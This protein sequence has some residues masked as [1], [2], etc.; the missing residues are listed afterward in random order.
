[1]AATSGSITVI[2]NP[3]AGSL[4]TDDEIRRRS[5][6]AAEVIAAHGERAD[7]YVTS[8]Q[9]EGLERARD[10]VAAG[11]RLVIAWGG[12]GTVNEVAAAVA[13]G[14]AAL[15]I[16]P[17]G[18]G[19]GLARD[20]R[21]DP[22]PAR[23]LAA[24]LEAPERTI[25]AGELGGRLFVNVA[26]VGFDAH[27]ARRFNARGPNARRGLATYAGLVLRESFAYAPAT[28]A[29]TA[30]GASL[31]RHRAFF[32]TLANSSQFGNGVRV[33]PA[34]RIDDGR[35]DLVVFAPP[36]RMAGLWRACGMLAGGLTAGADV[37]MIPVREV[38]IE[39]ATPLWFHVDGESVLGGH[40]LVGRVHPRAV[41]IRSADRG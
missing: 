8:G 27:V 20:L 36:S 32:V 3:M 6:L 38:A 18:S 2:I 39:G 4:V 5:G 17:A 41:R 28:Y 40:C 22:D 31:G 35:L 10:A 37:R 7:V 30:D 1:M 34:A 14:P 12:D 25:D 21:I 33:A 19:N 26:G 15:A 29:L 11:S 9:G 16:V 24:A 23:A 13:F